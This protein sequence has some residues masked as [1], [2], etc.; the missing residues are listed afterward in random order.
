MVVVGVV[1]LLIGAGDQIDCVTTPCPQPEGS[2]VLRM[3]DYVTI[4]FGV[5]VSCLGAIRAW[6]KRRRRS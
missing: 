4:A 2:T 6:L 5:A 1:L 3:S